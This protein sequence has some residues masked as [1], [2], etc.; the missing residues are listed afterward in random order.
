MDEPGQRLKRKRESL[1]L[2]YRDVEEASNLIAARKNSDEFVI[3]LSRLSD[4]ENKGTV[5]SIYRL[6]SLC[7]IYRMEVSEVLD[8]Y[9]VTLA[10][11]AADAASISLSKTHPIGFTAPPWGEVQMPLSLEPG[12]D[13]R[14]TFL[15]SRVI[16]R[17]GK[18][19]ISLLGNLELKHLRYAFVGSDDWRMYPLIYPES[20]LLIDDAQKKV[21]SSGWANEYERPIYFLEHRT[22]YHLGWC[23]IVE[24][25]L[26]VLAH[27]ASQSPPLIFVAEETDILGRVTGVAMHYDTGKRP[28]ATLN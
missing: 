28:P 16:Q 11:Q 15:V 26:V 21:T 27:P 19:P 12:L 8:W 4:M 24:K 25:N 22:G 9:G 10:T 1:G 5:P 23:S 18:M 6:Y 3:N 20:F 14:K 7:T 13:L 2:K 17:W